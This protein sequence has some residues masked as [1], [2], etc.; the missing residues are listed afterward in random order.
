MLD[1][2]IP[3]AVANG[4]VE[5]RG[6]ATGRDSAGFLAFLVER[7]LLD[8]RAGERAAVVQSQ[9]GQRIDAVLSQLGLLADRALIESLAAYFGLDVV[10]SQTLTAAPLPQC[11][12]EVEFLKRHRVVPLSLSD[13]ALVVAVADPFASDLEKAIAYLVERPVV[14]VLATAKDIDLALAE[15]F[16]AADNTPPS[17]G[18]AD[19]GRGFDDDV[20]RLR[21][22]ASEAPIIRLVNRLIAAAV[23]QQ[24]SDI[25]IEPMVDC[26]RV[27]HRIDGLLEEVECLP[28]DLEAGIVTRIKILAKLN[29]AERRL[30]QDGRTKFVVGGREVDLRIST[31]PVLHGENLVL[32]I[33]DSEQV[34]LSF[35]ALGFDDR[36][37]AS[38]SAVLSQPN[39]IIL[40]TG[41][42]GSG[43]T[44]TLYAALRSLN[45]IER[46]I[47]SIED[48]IEYQMRGISQ[49]QIKPEIGLNFVHCLRSILRQD[50]DVIMVGEMRDEPTAGTA[51]RAALTGHLVLSTL[52][53]NSAA[54]SVTRLLDM[55][56]EDYLL[57]SSLSCVL[58]QRLV[59]RLCASC[60]APA[61]EASTLARRLAADLPD[62][63]RTR[64]FDVRIPVGCPQCKHTGFRGRTTIAELLAV[65]QG[66][67]GSIK[68]GVSDR[69]IESKAR[70]NGMVTLHENG[71]HKVLAGETTLEEILRVAR[72]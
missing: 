4:P 25:H 54:A 35:E 55:G 10:V 69:E 46:K 52:H 59:R 72:V 65:D 19:P 16:G 22:M 31:T 9:T 56:A 57:A 18:N 38:L 68:R 14:T 1:P 2:L 24:A 71:I 37:R 48:P 3:T 28:R 61:P 49:I 15:H 43:K 13:D 58:A 67:R 60:S 64:S 20:Q 26:V 39:G 30:P 29:I 62:P 63:A 53:T 32:R 23:G 34:D 8:R 17:Q 12:L 45:S 5:P 6:H 66:V 41:P 42:T 33:L 21:D 36:T 40:V 11:G 27:R 7:S 70:R 47:F 51:I 44:T 50:P